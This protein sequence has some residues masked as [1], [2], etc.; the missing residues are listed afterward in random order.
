MR[1]S[2]TKAIAQ[3]I[4]KGLARED[5]VLKSMGNQ[6]YSYA[7]AADAVLGL[8]Y[9]LADGACGEA[10]NLAD[11]GSDITLKD[12]ANLVADISGRKVVFDLPS[13]TE[14]AGY[15]TA[16]RAVM[17]GEKLKA[18]GWRPQYDIRSG[19]KLTMGMLQNEF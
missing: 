15:S 16:T 5:I 8:L 19:I 17:C 6:L 14:R 3:F 9:V 12:L 10:Y 4:K 2:D 11:S 7:F 13:E 18:L 1:M